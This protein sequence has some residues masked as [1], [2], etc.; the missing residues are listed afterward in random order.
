MKIKLLNENSN[1]Y[2]KMNKGLFGDPSGKI[3]TFAIISPENPLG[4]KNS[5]EEEFRKKFNQWL[6][7][8][9]R[10]NKDAKR[11]LTTDELLHVIKDSGDKAIGYSGA[12]YTPLLGSYGSEERSYMIFNI[13]LVDAK[14][15]ARN[16]GQESFFYGKVYPGYSHIAYYE[17]DDACKTYHLVEVSDTVSDEDTA[18]DYFSRFGRKWRINMK[19]FGDNVSPIENEKEFEESFDEKSTFMGRA[20]HRRNSR[21]KEN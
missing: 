7:N 20:H 21:N 4:W 3:R 12:Q 9:G 8:P 2:R 5:T 1:R 6:D 15:I 11:T 13:P 19:T 14:K 16:Y 10:Y 18:T 17:T